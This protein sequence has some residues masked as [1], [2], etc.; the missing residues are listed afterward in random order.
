[1]RRIGPL[2]HKNPTVAA[3]LRDLIWSRVAQ[4]IHKLPDLM[5]LAFHF[6]RRVSGE[7]IA[8]LELRFGLGGV[9][10][11]LICV[12]QAVV[13]LLH[14]RIGLNGL[15]EFENRC[16]IFFLDRMDYSELE[17]SGRELWID[18]DRMVQ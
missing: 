6:P 1:M 18:T 5:A 12:G 8:E 11:L 15:P 17:I 13:R 2:R 3:R 10:N 4:D 14:R 9:S 7:L 16:P